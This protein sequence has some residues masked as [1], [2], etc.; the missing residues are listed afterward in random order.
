MKLVPWAYRWRLNWRI[1]R[2][3]NEL[4][5]LERA[6][7]GRNTPKERA[8]LLRRLD[9]IER[10]VITLKLPGS[11]ADQVYLLRQHINFV[12]TRL[13][14]GATTAASVPPAM[15]EEAR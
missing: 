8:D 6:A 15:P 9:E 3:Y 12:R 14:E 4:M 5:S 7:F 13:S 10:R 1:Y 2:R 11:F